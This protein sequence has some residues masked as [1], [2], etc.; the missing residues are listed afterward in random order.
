MRAEIDL[1]TPTAIWVLSAHV[2]TILSPLL[3]IWAVAANRG[4]IDGRLDHVSL[5]YVAA[6]VL[7]VASVSE[8]AQNTADKWWLTGTPP[9]ILDFVF[10]GLVVTSLA[11][12]VIA[13]YGS[14]A[15]V[16]V[17][18]LALVVVFVG[19]Y[20]GGLPTPIAQGLLGLWAA[21]ALFRA[22]DQ[23]VVFLSLV[24]VFLT[25]FFLDVLVRTLQQVMHGFVTGINGVGLMAMVIA[26]VAAAHGWRIGWIAVI[27]VTVVVVAVALAL[28]PWLLRLPATRRPSLTATQATLGPPSETRHGATPGAASTDVRTAT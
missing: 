9:S 21:Y 4:A 23:P 14:H 27:V 25:L 1:P 15:W 28:R 20:L 8:S 17:T 22:F 10:N 6:V 5:L 19:C 11:L 7:I 2:V 12:E 24:T 16:W 18:A 26:V 3:L 13:V